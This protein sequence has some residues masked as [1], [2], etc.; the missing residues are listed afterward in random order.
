MANADP[1]LTDPDV[2]GAAVG[3]RPLPPTPAPMPAISLFS[4]IPSEIMGFPLVAWGGGVV[5]LAIMVL[6]FGS[7]L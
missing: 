3:G 4:L 6:M 5:F 1:F 2:I 7:M